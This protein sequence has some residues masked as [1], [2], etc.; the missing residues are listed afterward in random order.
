VRGSF[1]P[2]GMNYPRSVA[3][4]PAS[5]EVWLPNYEGAPFIVV[6]DREFHHLRTVTTPRFVNDI[7]I[8]GGLAYLVVRRPGEVRVVD[9]ATGALVRTFPLPAEGRGVAVDPATGELWITADLSR[10][11][12]VSARPAIGAARSR[13][14][15]GAGA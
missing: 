5:G 14:T 8:V 10:D 6:Y 9:V 3:V 15:T 13:S 12:W 4:D 11:L 7:E 2:D 1:P